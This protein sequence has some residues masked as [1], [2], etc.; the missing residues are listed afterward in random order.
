MVVG[1]CYTKS[2]LETYSRKNIHENTLAET[3]LN[4]QNLSAKNQ[5][6]ELRKSYSPKYHRKMSD[7]K[8]KFQ[9]SSLG[10]GL[11]NP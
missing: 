8:Q 10:F 4:F 11:K 9:Q 5:T 3:L 7:F 6:K 1:A 2:K